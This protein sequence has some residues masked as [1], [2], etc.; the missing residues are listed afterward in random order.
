M[1]LYIAGPMTGIPQ[2]NYPA[3]FEMADILRD[4]GHT[5]VSPA[6]MDDPAIRAAS[7]A[8]RDGNI[9]TLES[10]GA[11]W[12]DFLARDVK[13]LAD[14]GIEGIVVLRGWQHSRGARLETFVARLRGIA[15]YEWSDEWGLMA[16]PPLMLYRAWTGEMSL[17]IGH[18][19]G[20]SASLVSEPWYCTDC[21]DYHQ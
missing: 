19:Y 12:G 16:V 8:S 21:R 7:F 6:E 4:E 10:H 11:T 3:F 5:V 1:K 13:L 9:H 18:R 17:T 14:D 2:F 15:I 20:Q